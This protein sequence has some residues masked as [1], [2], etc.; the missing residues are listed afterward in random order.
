M[1]SKRIER[2]LPLLL[3]AQQRNR[4]L[5]ENVSVIYLCIILDPLSGTIE[6]HDTWHDGQILSSGETSTKQV[7][8]LHVHVGILI[9]I[10]SLFWRV[11][12]RSALAR[13]RSS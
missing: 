8:V 13:G 9:E 11:L 5:L 2:T 3:A 4:A 1:I 6:G 10:F 12:I 7:Q